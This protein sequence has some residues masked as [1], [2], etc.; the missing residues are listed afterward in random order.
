M[1]PM[2]LRRPMAAPGRI[3]RH[4]EKAEAYLPRQLGWLAAMLRALKSDNRV[5]TPEACRAGL[6]ISA[7]RTGLKTQLLGPKSTEVN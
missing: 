7:G 4:S 6:A 3:V 1:V 5:T 2:N